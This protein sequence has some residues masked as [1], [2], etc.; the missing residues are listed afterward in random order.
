MLKKC[1]SWTI[2]TV[3]L[4]GFAPATQVNAE[5]PSYRAQS[6]ALSGLLN[7]AGSETLA[8][9]AAFWGSDLR[10]HYPDI[11]FRMD[12]GGSSTAPGALMDGSAHVGMMSRPM[13]AGENEAFARKFGYPPTEFRV[14]LD[15][16]VL[17]VHKDNP[18]KGLTLAQVDA[19]FS[20]TRKCGH[21]RDVT[22]WGQAGLAGD[23]ANRAI[24][25]LGRDPL[26]G[27]HGY[28]RDKGL[29]GGNFRKEV[30]SLASPADIMRSLTLLK[31]G[32][33]YSGTGHRNPELKAVPLAR[34]GNERFVDPTPDTIASGTYPLMRYLY[35]Y[36]NKAP[37]K[38]LPAL[39]H[40]F[41]KLILS[42]EGQRH[43]SNEGFVPLTAEAV[44][45]ERGKL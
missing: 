23:W 31:N 44:N 26:S 20:S 42:A 12:L 13:K 11:K 25:P 24:V 9:L 34:N 30:K 36:A 10:R 8:Y 40:E 19:I 21:D 39:E 28:F 22:A 1:H 35:V 27:T 14:A 29:C 3:L 38:P 6:G 43:V 5:P 37:G 4:I 17:Y 15:A 33:G 7:S 45:T 18:I 41:I 32:I 2:A 16:I